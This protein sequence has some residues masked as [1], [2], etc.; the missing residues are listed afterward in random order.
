MHGAL[1]G[2]VDVFELVVI[3]SMVLHINVIIH[4]VR[5]CLMNEMEN[6]KNLRGTISDEL[7]YC[8]TLTLMVDSLITKT[9][10]SL[11]S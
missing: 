8:K 3:A 6:E 4:L 10:S 11:T 1:T 7:N 5:R 2:E 9:L